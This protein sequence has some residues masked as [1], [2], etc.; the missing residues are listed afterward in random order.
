MEYRRVRV[1]GHFLHDKE[2][3]L[4]PRTFIDENSGQARG[5]VF[6][7]P[8]SGSGYLVITPFKLE[9]R[10]WVPYS[11]FIARMQRDTRK[12]IMHCFFPS[13]ETIL[14][15]RGWVPRNRLD[16]KTRPEGQVSDTIEL[17]GIVR[18][19]EARPQFTPKAKG[20]HFLFRYNPIQNKSFDIDSI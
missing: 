8:N 11:S 6:S 12:N 15:N 9:G 5:S 10:E 17:I 7:A 18:P 2:L 4:G 16:P 1:R 3:Y 20:T 13:S 19:G 14:V